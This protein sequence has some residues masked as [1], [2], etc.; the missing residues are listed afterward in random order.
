[1][2]RGLRRHGCTRGPFIALA[3]LAATFLSGCVETAID[4]EIVFRP[5]GS[6]SARVTIAMAKDGLA[7]VGSP[8]QITEK[9]RNDLPPGTTLQTRQNQKWAYWDITFSF[10]NPRDLQDKMNVIVGSIVG[11]KDKPEG[12]TYLSFTRTGGLFQA[13]YRYSAEV[14]IAFEGD[15]AVLAPYFRGWTHRVVL[16][17]RIVESNGTHAGERAQWSIPA[18][19]PLRVT[20]TS[21]AMNSSVIVLV[22]LGI[23][24]VGGVA[25]GL[26]MYARR[27]AR[28][29]RR[30]RWCDQCGAALPS[31]ARFCDSCGAPTGT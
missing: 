31:D 25:G 10:R 28:G 6:G 17:G 7:L 26:L 9:I 13:S 29:E 8:E 15:A 27:G 4:D 21:S 30:A 1:M 11:S 14:K 23:I 2:H 5:D 12:F 22:L 20:A 18:G 16:P 24:A 3:L 19:R